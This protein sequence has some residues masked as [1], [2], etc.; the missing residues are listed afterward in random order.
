VLPL[1]W[2]GSLPVKTD[3]SPVVIPLRH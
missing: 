1:S 2:T 3:S